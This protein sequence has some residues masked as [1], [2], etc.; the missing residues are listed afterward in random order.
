MKAISTPTASP[1]PSFQVIVSPAPP[2]KGDDD[3]FADLCHL[4]VSIRRRAESEGHR[5]VDGSGNPL[6]PLGQEDRP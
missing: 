3:R 4:L 6:P 2:D 5:F 1:Q